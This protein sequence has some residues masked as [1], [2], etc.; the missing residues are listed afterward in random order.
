MRFS[1]GGFS[2][3]KQ[4]YDLFGPVA[5]IF[6]KKQSRQNDLLGLKLSDRPPPFWHNFIFLL[7]YRCAYWAR[8]IR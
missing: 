3:P 1:W 8:P 4:L 6:A 5:S 2:F 7:F